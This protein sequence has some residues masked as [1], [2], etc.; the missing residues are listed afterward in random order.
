MVFS[1]NHRPIRT[2]NDDDPMPNV[3]AEALQGAWSAPGLVVQ[4][5]RN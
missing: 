1:P 4:L 2:L 3:T 5:T